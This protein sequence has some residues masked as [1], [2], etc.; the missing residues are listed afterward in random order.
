MVLFEVNSHHNT[1][2]TLPL[3]HAVCYEPTC[4]LLADLDHLV[5]A[6]FRWNWVCS[7]LAGNVCGDYGLALQSSAEDENAD[8]AGGEGEDSDFCHESA[9]YQG[10]VEPGDTMTFQFW[11]EFAEIEKKLIQAD[12]KKGN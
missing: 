7:R 9:I 5:N 2:G 4:T 1:S 12:V 8:D 6:T 11:D 10:T 3:P